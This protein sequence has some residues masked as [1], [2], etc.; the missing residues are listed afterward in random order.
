MT[1]EVAVNGKNVTVYGVTPE[2]FFL[3]LHKFPVLQE[4]FSG[5]D[6]EVSMDALRSVGAEC[7]AY[8]LAVAT[9]SR[10]YMT[11]KEWIDI[12]EATANIVLNVNANAQRMLFQATIRLTFPEGIGPFMLG[13]DALTESINQVSGQTVPVTTS[14]K[15]SRSGFVTDS[16]GM[17]LGRT[18]PRASSRH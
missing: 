12:V 5:G 17:R 18:A 3:L 16:L 1:E 8:A 11:Q 2:G 14:S 13:V 7:V 10:S 4:M 9:T 15:P 6:K